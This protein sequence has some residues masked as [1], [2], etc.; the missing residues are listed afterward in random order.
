MTE[1]A[2][3]IS[4]GEP[5]TTGEDIDKSTVSRHKGFVARVNLS[6]DQAVFEEFSAQA[7]RKDKTLFAFANESLSAMAKITAEGGEPSDLYKFWRSIALLKQTDIITLPSDFV[8]RLIAREYASD[9]EGLLKMFSDLGSELVGVLKFGA[10]D[11]SELAALATDFT[12]LLPIK[13][14][15]ISQSQKDD[16][17]E[18]GIVG[19]G[20]RIESTECSFVFLQS[21]LN[22]Y[23]YTVTNHDINIGTIMVRASKRRLS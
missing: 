10:K 4:E 2:G 13:Q 8:D 16:S 1:V 9:K 6:V 7:K 14:F 23:G 19:A 15:K 11:L 20:R 3:Q 5:G 12:A 18:I 21:I 22:G 17:V